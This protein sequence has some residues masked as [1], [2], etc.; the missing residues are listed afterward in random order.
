MA[1]G[2]E[3]AVC[4]ADT[5]DIAGINTLTA[6]IEL[7][8]IYHKITD[9]T[10]VV[11]VVITQCNIITVIGGVSDIECAVLESKVVDGSFRD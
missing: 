10:V 5:V 11:L 9:F 8:V 2:I 3:G 6:I 4:Y 7:A 1:G